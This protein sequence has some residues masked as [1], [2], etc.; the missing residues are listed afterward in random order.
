MDISKG[1]V[2]LFDYKLTNDNGE[3]IDSSE[4]REPLAYMHGAGQ[5]VPG[6][7]K[8]LE[9]KSTGDNVQ[10]AVQPQ[11]GYG[12]RDETLVG[13]IPMTQ[14]QGVEKVE[15]GMQFRASTPQ[16]AQIITVQKV[17]EENVTVDA[18]HPLAGETLNFD[19]T[20]REVREATEEELNHGHAHGPGGHEH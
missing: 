18:N 12:E 9:G 14:F 8:Q 16:G 11:E 2:V 3:L 10:T 4:G 6:L 15:P 17:E 19:V 13:I 7:E 20:I 1:K 5:I